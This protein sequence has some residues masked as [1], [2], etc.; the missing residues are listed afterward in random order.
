MCFRSNLQCVF[1]VTYNVFSQQLTTRLNSNVQC[2]FSIM[3][4]VFSLSVALRFL[5]ALAKLRKTTISFVIKL[6]VFH[7]VH[8]HICYNKD[9]QQMR[10]SFVLCLYFLFL[11]FSLHVSSFH[12]PIIRGSPAVVFML[13]FGSCIALL[14]VCVRQRAGLWW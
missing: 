5:G 14:I 13:P 1:T 2:I 8:L 3:Y 9:Y 6:Q 11:V 10:L 4:S 7:T 12:K